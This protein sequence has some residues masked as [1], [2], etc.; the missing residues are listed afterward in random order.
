M[1]FNEYNNSLNNNSLN[2]S[3]N[4]TSLNNTNMSSQQ[5]YNKLTSDNNFG[6]NNNGINNNLNNANTMNNMNNYNMNNTLNNVNTPQASYNITHGSIEF[7]VNYSLKDGKPFVG[8]TY[9]NI[10]VTVKSLR[11]VSYLNKFNQ[12]DIFIGYPNIKLNKINPKTNKEMYYNVVKL[13]Q[14]IENDII[15]KYYLFCKTFNI[16]I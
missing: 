14:V 3:S 4:T 6:I 16:N 13:N 1:D 9:K 15:Q 10:L 12:K 2:N 8:V 7:K 5:V 11:V